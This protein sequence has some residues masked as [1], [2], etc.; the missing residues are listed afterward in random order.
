MSV[1]GI[2]KVTSTVGWYATTPEQELAGD[3]A[4]PGATL[5][6]AVDGYVLTADDNIVHS[7][8]TLTYHIS[9]PVRYVFNFVNASNAVQSDLDNALL[10]GAAHFK[11]D[12]MLTRDV[13]P[14]SGC[15]PPARDRL[16][17]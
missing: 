1:S 2:K 5:N 8:V 4:M 14:V 6:P 17:G 11:V 3:Q 16:G 10:Y 15:R 9:D 13:S 12:D 7:R